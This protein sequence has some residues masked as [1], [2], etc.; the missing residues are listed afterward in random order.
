M[1]TYDVLIVGGGAAGLSAALV[2]ARA[3][4]S[5]VVVDAGHPRNAPAA[6]MHGFLGSDGLPPSELL[7]AGRREAIGYGATIVTA[8]VS[9]VRPTGTAVE[10]GQSFEADLDQGGVVRARRILVTTGLQDE[11][12]AIPGLRER[13]GRDVLHCPYCHGHE[14]RDEPVGVIGGSDET[15]AHAQLV[16]QWAS[17]VIYFAH[18]SVVTAEHRERL[19]ARDVSIIDEPVDR[20]VVENDRLAGV[21][22]ATG[23]TVARSAVFVRPR[24]VPSSTLLQTLGCTADAAGWVA[25]DATGHTSRP[26]VWAAGN[27]VNPRAQVI[28]AAGEGSSAAIAINNDLVEEDV[29]IAV[30]R[31]R[32]ALR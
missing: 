24:L 8:S 11:L 2:L 16:R 31:R 19:E 18:G 13:W 7:A 12:P 3:Q 17:D 28:T 14:V 20:I 30:R 27:A 1:N 32:S 9:G 15:I 10:A 23:E 26:G 29:A 21:R 22:L 25:V 6:H 4:R 5:V